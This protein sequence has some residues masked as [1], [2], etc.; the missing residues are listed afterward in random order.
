MICN[1]FGPELEWHDLWLKDFEERLYPQGYELL[2]ITNE[3]WWATR[4]RQAL[5]VA[6]P[7]GADPRKACDYRACF[8]VMFG[9]ELSNG[10]Y[11]WWG[12]TDLD[13][14]YGRV[15]RFMTED[16]LAGHD[17]VANHHDYVSG[18]W[19]L[20]RRRLEV[21]LLYQRHEDWV[22]HLENPET[23]GWVETS[24]TRLV[25]EAH[26]AGEIRRLYG[27]WQT[28]NLN[29][30]SALRRGGDGALLEGGTEVMMAHFRRTKAYP[31]GCR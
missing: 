10:N 8:G 6:W 18:P 9:K 23:T 7:G 17:I 24:F 2:L 13:C 16:L 31:E 22:G 19:T 29:D 4:A 5:G 30:F 15:E 21:D 12:H 1:W 11:D 14:V 27:Y 20:Y 25:D 3:R 26:D 28:E